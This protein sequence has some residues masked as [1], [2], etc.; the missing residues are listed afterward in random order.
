[1]L[2]SKRDEFKL[3]VI[4]GL[5]FDLSALVFEI[6]SALLFPILQFCVYNFEILIFDPWTRP[7]NIVN[8][9]Y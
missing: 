8:N 3:A 4:C 6:G 7:N 1:M 9:V 5:Q 2:R